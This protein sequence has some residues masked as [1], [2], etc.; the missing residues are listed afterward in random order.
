MLA[1][2][3]RTSRLLLSVRIPLLRRRSP[4]TV[5]GSRCR[6]T[7]ACAAAAVESIV[8]AGVAVAQETGPKPP[9]DSGLFAPK[10]AW[11]APEPWR[12]DRFYLQT[13][14]ATI[15]FHYDSAHEQSVALDLIYRFDERW[16]GGQWIAGGALFTNSFGQFSQVVYGG[17][18]W[19]PL[20]EYQPFYLKVGA[21]VIH[22]YSG[23]YQ[24]KIP[25]NST[26]FAPAIVPSAGYCWGRYCSE[27][28][29]LGFNALMIT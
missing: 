24:D 2:I 16:L 13:A 26:G 7:R 21:G 23:A 27:V 12:T 9:A 14:I 22:G 25:Y 8:G 6:W 28:V 10:P 11:D 5:P 15:H 1:R 4:T 17:L 18:L 29:L 19:R 3:R 20:E